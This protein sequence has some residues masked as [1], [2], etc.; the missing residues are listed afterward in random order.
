MLA[1]MVCWSGL[2]WG[3]GRDLAVQV[4][5]VGEEI[6]THVSLFVPVARERVWEVITDYERAPEY[7][8]D[9]QTSRVLAR[10]GDRLRLLQRAL[11]R[12]GPFSVPVETLREIRLTA[13]ARTEARLVA[14]SMRKYDSVTE[15]IPEGSGTRVI[16][17][18]QAIPSSAL[19]AFAGESFVRR[20]TEEHFRELRAEILRR[21]HV[22]VRN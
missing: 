9:L 13:P 4:E 5:T 12:F 1:L 7:S 11:V 21:E 14:G 20:E 22:A 16:V 2:S 15:L 3:G 18:A 19:A 6:R 8:R 10:S 17:R